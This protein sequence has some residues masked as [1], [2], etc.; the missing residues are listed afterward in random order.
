[1]SEP[2]VP[3]MTTAPEPARPVGFL[4]P[5]TVIFVALH[6]L[7]CCVLAGLLI[8]FVPRAERIFRDFNI[9]PPDATIAVLA[10]GR[11]FVLYWYVV[12]PFFLAWLVLAGLLLAFLDRRHRALAWLWALLLLLLPLAA[13]GFVLFTILGP[14]MT[15]LEAL[16]G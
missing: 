15:L 12:P 16:H 5:F 11:W 8:Y 13:G 1:M 14:L 6:A 10:T 2:Y 4:R 9:R 3:A 7:F